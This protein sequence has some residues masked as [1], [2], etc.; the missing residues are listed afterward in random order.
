MRKINLLDWRGEL[1]KQNQKNLG[2]ACAIAFA[3]GLLVF[4]GVTYFYNSWI[5]HQDSRNR[6]LTKE[7]K[8]L[9]AEIKEVEELERT[10]ERLIARM[11]VIDNLQQSRPLV[12]Q[13]F[14]DMARIIPEGTYF[15][16][17]KQ[18]GNKIQFEGRTQSSTRVSRLMRN[19]AAA[20][21]LKDPDVD[22]KG[23]VT[24]R[25]GG[26]RVSEFGLVAQIDTKSVE[27]EE[28]EE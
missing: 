2:I 25:Q 13:V 21:T 23:I 10:K 24:D 20:P 14:D 11:N 28:D 16:K 1:V 12:V 6:L 9:E 26:I 15:D 4:G 8:V 27:T 19:I 22:T 3:L 7:I 5:D 18:T 17:A